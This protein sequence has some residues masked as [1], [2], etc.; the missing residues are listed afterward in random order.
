M[1][2]IYPK[3]IQTTTGHSIKHATQEITNPSNLCSGNTKLA[4]W[5][6]KNP[7]YVGVFMRNYYDSVTTI[8]GSY[9]KPETIYATSWDFGKINPK[10][11]VNK[12][13]IQYKWEQVSYSCGTWDC[14]GRF[15]KPTISIIAKG[16]TIDSKYGAKPEAI[17]YHNNKTNEK[18]MNTNNAELATLHSHTFNVKN[19]KLTI[20]DLQ[21]MKIKFDPAKNTYHEY[22]RIIMQFIRIKVDYTEPKAASVEIPPAFRITNAK[23]TPSEAW[24]EGA[25]PNKITEPWTYTC[26]VKNTNSHT[27]PTKVIVKPLEQDTVIVPGTYPSNYNPTTHVWSI[28]NFNNHQATLTFKAQSKQVGKKTIRANVVDYPDSINAQVDAS[29]D[30]ID[31]PN[32]LTWDIIIVGDKKPYIYDGS[33]GDTIAK[34]LQLYIRR[35]QDQADRNEKITLNTDGWLTSN[36]KWVVDSDAEQE[37]PVYKENGIWEFNNIK[38]KYVNFTATSSNDTCVIVPPGRYNITALHT[39]KKRVDEERN[40]TMAVSGTSMPLDYFKLRLEDGSDVRYN[41]LMV[42]PGDD[43]TTPLTYVIENDDLIKKIKLTGETKRIP[44]NEARYIS[45]NIKSEVDLENILCKIKVIDINTNEDCSEIIIGGDNQVQIIDGD[46]DKF[47]IIDNVKAGKEKKINFI[48]QSDIQC[49]YKFELQ[50][51]NDPQPYIDG[52]WIASHIYVQDLPN[53]K[54][55]IETDKDDLTLAAGNNKVKVDYVIE[56]KSRVIGRNLKFKIT[57]PTS[58]KITNF[59]VNNETVDYYI[60]GSYADTPVPYFNPKTRILTVPEIKG[61]EQASNEYVSEKYTLH[62]EYEATQKGIYDFIIETIDDK[63]SIED[64]QRQNYSIKKVLV[65]IQS[66]TNIKTSVNNDKPYINEL[67]DFSIDVKNYIKEQENFNFVIKD[68]GAYNQLHNKNDYKYEYA[69]CDRGTYT[70]NTDDNNTIGTWQIDH[71]NVNDST[72]LILSLRPQD[73]G[74]HIIETTFTDSSGQTQ[75]FENVVNVLEQYKKIAMNAYHAI[76]NC[77]EEDSLIEICDNDDIYIGDSFFYVFEITNNGKNPVDTPTHIYVRAPKSFLE[78]DIE[79][80]TPDVDINKEDNGLI[81]ITIPY[82]KACDTKKIYFKVC[83]NRIGSY[84]TNIMLTNKNTHVIHKQLKI[85]VRN[86]F[87]QKQLEHEI[88]IYNFEKTN[89]YFR[90]ELDNQNNIFKFFNKGDKSL[91]TVDIENYNQKSVETYRGANLKKLVRDIQNNSIYVEPELLR[92]GTN[93]LTPKGYELYPDGFMRRFGLL[94]SEVFHYTGQLPTISNMADKA[95]RWDVDGWDTK[96]WGGDIYDNGVFDLTID[97]GRIPKNFNILEVPD[98]VKNLQTLVDRVKPYGTQAI[99]YYSSKIYLDLNM[100]VN[101]GPIEGNATTWL[102]VKI[103]DH[104][105]LVS[106]YN[107]HDNSIA[108]YYDMIKHTLTP[109]IDVEVEEYSEPSNNDIFKVK[110]DVSV[111][112]EIYDQSYSKKY[113]SDCLDI[114]Q[115]LYSNNQTI[116]NIDIIK[117]F[118][119]NGSVNNDTSFELNQKDVWTFECGPEAKTILKIGD[120]EEYTIQYK[121]DDIN[122]F[123]GFTVQNSDEEN[124]FL[125]NFY[126]NIYTF[127]I[128]LQCYDIDQISLNDKKIIHIFIAPNK[129]KYIH[130]GYIITDKLNKVVITSNDHNTA[131]KTSED[132]P[133]KFQ[134]KDSINTITQKPNRIIEF[135]NNIWNNINNIKEEG[136]AHIDNNNDIDVECKHQF[137]KTPILGLKYNSIDLDNNDE[138][139]DIG[140]KIKAKSNK[141][142]FIDDINVGIY[143]DGD[144]YVP[145]N[146]IAK[147]IYYPETV[148]N[149]N[150]EYISNLIIQQPNISICSNCLKT[151][152]G[153]YDECPFCHSNNISHYDEKKAV[154]I[155]HN[156]GWITNGWNNT[157]THCLSTDIE[158]TKVD[159]NKT[160]CYKCGA[161]EDDY[162]PVCPKCFSSNIIHMNNDENKFL[163]KN[164]DTQNID[165]VI[166]KSDTN[167]INLINIKVP[168][169]LNTPTIES[170]EHLNLHLYGTNHNDGKFYYCPEC[171]SVGLGHMDKCPQCDKESIENYTFNNLKMSIYNQTGDSN[172]IVDITESYDDNHFDISIDLL[173]LIKENKQPSFTLIVY[174]EN[175]V[176]DQINAKIEDLNI[177]GDDYDLLV[178]NIPV[179]NISLDNIYY[180]SKYINETEWKNLNNI[181]GRNHA[182]I[183]YKTNDEESTEYIKF[184]DFNILNKKYEHLYFN[185]RGLNKSDKHIKL[186]I[187]LT[188]EQNKTYSTTIEGITPNLFENKIDLLDIAPSEKIINSSI[189]IRFNRTDKNNEIFITHAYILAETIQNRNVLKLIDHD[190]KKIKEADTYL[191]TSKNMFNFNND[192]PYY[193]DGI[194]MQTNLICYLD[195]GKLDN[196]QYIRLYD[197]EIVILYKNRYGKIITDTTQVTPRTPETAYPQYT[198]QL[199]SG[200]IQSYNAETWG[201]IESS[202]SVLNNL[203][204]QIFTNDNEELLESIPLSQTLTQAFTNVDNNISSITLNY[205]GAVGYPQDTITVQ[206]YDD[207]GNSPDSLLFSRDI[208]LP[209]ARGN[210][211]I[212]INLD[213]LKINEQYWIKLID[214]TANENNYHKF[215]HNTNLTVGNLMINDYKN[216]NNVLSFSVNGSTTLQEYYNLPASINADDID[217]FK[218]SQ[219]F[220]RYNTK[221]S[222]NVTL[223][224]FEVQNGYT[225]YDN[226][227]INAISNADDDEEE[228]EE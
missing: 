100:N 17:R 58:F 125:T 28:N 46:I 134:V 155:C 218:N 30:V 219:V 86:S 122:S 173:P 29:L 196:Y 182:G 83:P 4:Y 141:E 19:A 54:M 61:E 39:E 53:I 48:V 129:H 179:M 202:I 174:A 176:Y 24:L 146:N 108:A 75:K 112:G 33:K 38:G 194:Q 67:I 127:N 206:I 161:L 36:I 184:S 41:S 95:M 224:N 158:K 133:V 72:K 98:P 85:N 126:T 198:K 76:G 18:Y 165:P 145:E 79:C 64:D 130:I 154:T 166:I 114:V 68:I 27:K 3:K 111:I 44:T 120:N 88:T 128:Q 172:N 110:T 113:I 107:K 214:N 49:T 51:F 47:C 220:Y 42:T 119:Y 93:K 221:T 32:N 216:E 148:S 35:D 190:N 156:C 207:Y 25:K 59:T 168:L 187:T 208:T 62:I 20:K 10:S 40:L 121:K 132:V 63:T 12:I 170:L 74:Y 181:N 23:I 199:I 193:T 1:G 143:K 151:S 150:N 31:P 135:N 9:Y 204:S 203:E 84:V 6:V 197:A 11:T 177:D 14:Y 45:Y 65:N 180:E 210:I 215:Y 118:N 34:C 102:P 97:Y 60:Y 43:L 105:G 57:E 103:Y 139:I 169:N 55:S 209:F 71:M 164:K 212:D 188:D 157:C 191:I 96:V 21:N 7:T 101:L 213:D 211:T 124:I 185:I 183:S 175:T 115:S 81:H 5:G 104:I 153:L 117:N 136:Y 131:Q 227:Y 223:S 171:K 144:K 90:Y 2:Y 73:I 91:R 152:L 22:C 186:D 225:Y 192:I 163:I 205:A 147:E 8:S 178:D 50:A 15:D 56:N 142:N 160:Y 167:R 26:T 149:V 200:D 201:T 70:N 52:R 123:S 109:N 162:Y 189:K 94:N 80:M 66:S 37:P 99:C 217:N 226:T 87:N 82:I 222:S 228:E 89:R 195:F 13:T 138:I 78:N 140:L 16:K 69:T 159:Y 116:K 137:L 106:L 77:G 92:V